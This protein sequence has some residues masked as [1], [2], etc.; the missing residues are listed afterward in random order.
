MHLWLPFY[1]G[2]FQKD[3]KKK[4][5]RKKKK[6]NK[7]KRKGEKKGGAIKGGKEWSAYQCAD[8]TAG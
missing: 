3:F 8:F 2:E 1:T 4:K 6:E 7:K 5:K